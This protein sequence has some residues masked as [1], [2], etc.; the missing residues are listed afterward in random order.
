M[1]LPCAEGRRGA[2]GRLCPEKDHAPHTADGSLAL[3]IC[4]APGSA[5]RAGLS[6]A[7]TGIDYMAAL[8]IAP[9]ACDHDTLK[10]LLLQAEAGLIEGLAERSPES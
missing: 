10:E 6:G 9:G 7:L 4:F 8:A 3:Q 2:N 1:G 5:R